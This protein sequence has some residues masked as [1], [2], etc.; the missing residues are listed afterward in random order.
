MES[1][2]SLN[3]KNSQS[4]TSQY[5]LGKKFGHRRAATLRQDL[6]KTIAMEKLL[7]NKEIGEKYSQIRRKK[8]N[9][10]HK[11][12]NL[13]NMT[14]QTYKGTPKI[15]YTYQ[16][17]LVSELEVDIQNMNN[18]FG[19]KESQLSLEIDMLSTKLEEEKSI[20][21]STKK[22]LDLHNKKV[23]LIVK[24]IDH[25]IASSHK[26]IHRHKVSI[27]SENEIF[28]KNANTIFS[29][30]SSKVDKKCKQSKPLSLEENCSMLQQKIEELLQ[31]HKQLRDQ[32]KE[33]RN[34]G[35]ESLEEISEKAKRL[36]LDLML[37]SENFENYSQQLDLG[38]LKERCITPSGLYFTISHQTPFGNILFTGKDTGEK[39]VYD[40]SGYLT[41]GKNKVNEK[42]STHSRHK[43]F[44]Q[45]LVNS[46]QSTKDCLSS[47]WEDD[48]D[49]TNC[50]KCGTKFWLLSRKHHCRI[51]GK[52]FCGNCSKFSVLLKGSKERS[53][54][55]CKEMI[56]ER[57]HL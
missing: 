28:A 43:S 24:R 47:E 3:S 31:A 33:N 55:T 40:K 34:Q 49:I 39:E 4:K 45:K 2:F 16:S 44:N 38:E 26:A 30:E 21:T 18:E 37:E 23:E 14:S 36:N 15:I 42:I 46:S 22:I 13:S 10:T 56:Q 11:S 35:E 51:C 19:I 53:C 50:T 7:K 29:N 1:T 41:T 54:L 27:G 57:T 48:K 8:T 17:D 32:L 9:A 12:K 20:N 6:E 5:S 25:N 52:I